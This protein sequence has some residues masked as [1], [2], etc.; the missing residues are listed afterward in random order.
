MKYFLP[1][2]FQNHGGKARTFDRRSSVE[3]CTMGGEER[4]I[5]RYGVFGT[6]LK[7]WVVTQARGTP[8]GIFLPRRPFLREGSNDATEF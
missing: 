2:G 4:A 5:R 8:L 7:L 6:T 1:Y 3:C